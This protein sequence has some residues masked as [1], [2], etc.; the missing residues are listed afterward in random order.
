MHL[1]EG[2]CWRDVRLI[3]LYH[4]EWPEMAPRRGQG[5]ARVEPSRAE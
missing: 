2:S 1:G 3:G 4:G 5:P